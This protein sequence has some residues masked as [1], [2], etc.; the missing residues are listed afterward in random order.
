MAKGNLPSKQALEV[1]V[2]ALGHNL[3]VLHKIKRGML[4]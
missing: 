4:Y 3:K 2:V 1:M